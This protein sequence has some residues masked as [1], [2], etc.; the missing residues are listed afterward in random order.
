MKKFKKL[1]I[2]L[3][4]AFTLITTVMAAGGQFT[5]LGFGA[6][7]SQVWRN[8][9]KG[10]PSS[11]YEQLVDSDATAIS[12]NILYGDTRPLV[13]YLGELPAE[14]DTPE[15][16]SAT[17]P[18]SNRVKPISDTNYWGYI[19]TEMEGVIN[20][21][22]KPNAFETTLVDIALSGKSLRLYTLLFSSTKA[23]GLANVKNF[24]YSIVSKIIQLACQIKNI[25]M[26][27]IVNALKLPGLTN[28]I[29]NI[30]IFNPQGGYSPFLLIALIGMI[31]AMVSTFSKYV[32]D[33][34]N[35]KEVRGL[36]VNTLVAFMLIGLAMYGRQHTVAHTVSNLGGKL[37]LDIAYSTNSNSELFKTYSSDETLNLTNNEMAI[38]SKM[39]I[40][41][42]IEENLGLPIQQLQIAPGG[43]FDSAYTHLLEG[44]NDEAC[45]SNLGYYFWYANSEAGNLDRKD[46]GA[47]GVSPDKKLDSVVTYLQACYN[48][49][50]TNDKL[51][52]LSVMRSLGDTTTT[53]RGGINSLLSLAIM[54]FLGVNLFTLV[55]ECIFGK[56]ELALGTLGISVAGPLL[57]F[58]NDKLKESAYT[59]LVMF[60][61]GFLRFTVYSLLFDML[62]AITAYLCSTTLTIN[63]LV[64]LALLVFLFFLVMPKVKVKVE[65]VFK[66]IVSSMGRNTGN[67]GTVSKN[68]RKTIGKYLG[69][70][71]SQLEE[72]K[73]IYDDEG[74]EI[75]LDNKNNIFSQ[76]LR[77]LKANLEQDTYYKPLDTITNTKTASS[78]RQT[79]L[80]AQQINNLLGK[81]TR[82]NNKIEETKEALA[83]DHLLDKLK[84]FTLDNINVK[85][86]DKD[87]YNKYNSAAKL[88]SQI[89]NMDET[90]KSV[91]SNLDRPDLTENQKEEFVEK[92]TKLNKQRN[93]LL[94]Y[95]DAFIKQI[96][97]EVREKADK[98]ANEAN[99]EQLHSVNE[100]YNKAIS[101]AASNKQL[102][103]KMAREKNAATH[104]EQQEFKDAVEEVVKKENMSAKELTKYNAELSTQE[105]KEQ[106]AQEDTY[107]QRQELMAKGE[108]VLNPKPEE[109]TN[110]ENKEPVED[111]KE[112][113]K[114]IE[115]KQEQPK[116]TEEPKPK[117]QPK[118]M[119]EPKEQV[120]P[121]EQVKPK[122]QPKPKVKTEVTPE[123]KTIGTITFFEPEPVFTST[124]ISNDDLELQDYPEELP[125]DEHGN[126]ILG[127]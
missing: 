74:N 45:G 52:L 38:V 42:T 43:V 57:L 75:E 2:V 13:T 98:D 100:A 76:G 63:L 62:L 34:S 112:E 60:L 78:N 77:M 19:Q 10:T 30:F 20:N 93:N 4:T 80:M 25:T 50:G 59:I 70:K 96:E 48:N 15:F 109:K 14:V 67:Y 66:G 61:M 33:G 121:R 40:D 17:Y 94:S 101:N 105:M 18:R 91:R 35:R 71:A 117:E 58:N 125:L 27:Q 21:S 107:N 111:K 11:V 7:K 53:L 22:N 103:D 68:I 23:N 104:T 115:S 36:L 86:L 127:D 99:K 79:R 108:E 64:T 12:F 37:M 92:L 110:E 123:G 65:E 88:Q 3:F 87:L 54:V 116:P 69:N 31:I 85:K 126:P 46:L 32:K 113:V 1:I 124:D 9:S 24:L 47:Y 82:L 122:E 41:I 29:N 6:D 90:I 5:R 8:T 97:F 16:H 55:I 89:D 84:G 28:I 120:K 72:N 81:R 95:Q 106:M 118:P 73:I 39:N 44:Y 51:A 56:L 119:E 102:L 83:N 114:P 49:A 26:E